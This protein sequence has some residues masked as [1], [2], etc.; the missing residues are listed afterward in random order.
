MCVIPKRPRFTTGFV[1]TLTAHAT[2]AFRMP[3]S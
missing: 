2:C 1:V 3:I